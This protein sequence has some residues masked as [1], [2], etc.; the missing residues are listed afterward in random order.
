MTLAVAALSPEKNCALFFL[1][2]SITH[3]EARSK[4]SIVWLRHSHTK[5]D[6]SI[7]YP[8]AKTTAV[9][10]LNSSSLRCSTLL[11]NKH[12]LTH[13][14]SFTFPGKYGASAE[15]MQ[16]SHSDLCSAA[17]LSLFLR[18]F[19]FTIMING[20]VEEQKKVRKVEQDHF[21]NTDKCKQNKTWHK[22]Y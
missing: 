14:D 6:N 21:V 1:Y 18:L 8:F 19:F 12:T 9:V 16:C 4:K 17:S 5:L 13:T 2:L 15:L 20:S 3:K 22:H 10:L 7:K 11:S